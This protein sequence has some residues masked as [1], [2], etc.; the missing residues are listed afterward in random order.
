M[1]AFNPELT[2]ERDDDRLGDLVALDVAG[3]ASVAARLP[4][5]HLLQHEAL[6]GDDDAVGLVVQHLLALIDRGET[7]QMS[8]G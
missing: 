4:A 5:R 2:H 6:V 3:L 1:H 8:S 7:F